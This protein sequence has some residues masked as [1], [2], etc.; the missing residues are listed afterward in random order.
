MDTFV[1]DLQDHLS[2]GEMRPDVSAGIISREDTLEESTYTYIQLW[3]YLC[4]IKR[5]PETRV[6][7]TEI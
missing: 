3:E 1:S 5:R 2:R 7:E 4:H 6:A